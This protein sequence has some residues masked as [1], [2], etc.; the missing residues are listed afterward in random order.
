MTALDRRTFLRRLGFGTVAAAAA[1]TSVFDL[2]RLLWIPGEKRLFVPP[3]GA[4]RMTD[5]PLGIAIRFVREFDI[6]FSQ[7]PITRFDYWPDGL[8][9]G[10]GAS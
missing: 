6:D 9:K 10:A 8:V 7:L 5:G 2:E 4:W 1:A 3:P